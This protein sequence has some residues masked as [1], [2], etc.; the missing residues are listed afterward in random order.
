MT[1][2]LSDR[3]AAPVAPWLI[4]TL[5]LLCLPASASA[6]VI[7]DFEAGI[8]GLVHNT[9][10][11]SAQTSLPPIHCIAPVREVAIHVNEA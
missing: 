1:L 9:L 7:D 3:D 6:Q 11:F 2:F 4:S 5:L 10:D 8:F